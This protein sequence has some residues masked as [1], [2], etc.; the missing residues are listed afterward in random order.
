GLP[1]LTTFIAVAFIYVLLSFS[2]FAIKGVAFFNWADL[3][4]DDGEENMGGLQVNAFYAPVSHFV[5]IPTLYENPATAAEEVTLDSSVNGFTFDVGK[6]FLK[7]YLT[8]ETGEIIDEPQGELDGQSFKHIAN[9]F[10]PGS[11][12][13]A[14]SFMKAVNNSNM[15]FVF[16]EANG[17]M[18]TIGSEAFPARVKASATTGKAIADRKGI[19][20]EIFSY[21]YTPAPIY[22]GPIPLTPAI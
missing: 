18:R 9:C 12:A 3:S 22:D 13:E 1:M 8:L 20:L 10:Y 17:Q 5:N 19:S 2:S 16:S 14:L 6:M 7:L 11:K 21:G 4:H 15:I